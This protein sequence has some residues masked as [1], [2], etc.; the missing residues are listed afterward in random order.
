[1]SLRERMRRS[2][3]SSFTASPSTTQNSVVIG[4]DP[5]MQATFDAVTAINTMRN[6][7]N[8]AVHLDP[9]LALSLR[10]RIYSK[11]QVPTGISD[12]LGLPPK[13]LPQ[14]L[15]NETA[16]REHIW[17]RDRVST[18]L[19]DAFGLDTPQNHHDWQGD[20]SS[21]ISFFSEYD[22]VPF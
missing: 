3:S 21:D 17:T 15:H 16:R 1:M 6:K 10:R 18:E 19:Q 13:T 12:E 14:S 11:M 8:R 20:D 9:T 4:L 7:T 2:S 22:G 5:E